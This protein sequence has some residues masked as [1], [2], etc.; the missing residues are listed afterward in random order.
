[1]SRMLMFVFGLAVGFAAAFL[2][3]A[4][5]SPDAPPPV[6]PPVQPR[7]PD[8]AARSEPADRRAEDRPRRAAADPL[9]GFDEGDLPA[10]TPGTG[11]ITGRVLD[12]A[13]HGL[14]GAT[15]R[16]TPQDDPPPVRETAT[17]DPDEELR[18]NVRD[19]VRR[20]RFDR[21]WGRDAVTDAAGAFV[22]QGLAAR[23]WC[24]RAT[25]EGWDIGRA[26]GR[27]DWQAVRIG[28]EVAFTAR[29]TFLVEV[30]VMRPDG[31]P[32]ETAKVLVGERQSDS[33]PVDWNPDAPRMPLRAGKWILSATSGA[34]SEWRS[35]DVDVEVG[36]TAAPAPIR[37]VLAERPGVIV[38]LGAAGP[39]GP[40]EAC[41]FLKPEGVPAPASAAGR[42]R[43]PEDADKAKSKRVAP[44]ERTAFLDVAAGRWT[45]SLENG[46]G[47]EFYSE[48]LDVG[49]G[50]I[51]RDVALPDRDLRDWVVARVVGPD[52][53]PVAD[54]RFS[55]GYAAPGGFADGGVEA[56]RLDDSR[57]RVPAFPTGSSGSSSSTGDPDSSKATRRWIVAQ[58]AVLGSTHADIDPASGA[59]VELRFGTPA[60]L[61][62]KIEGAL[63][64]GPHLEVAVGNAEESGGTSPIVDGVYERRD[65]EGDAV[66]FGPF[67]PREASVELSSTDADDNR[68]DLASVKVSLVAGENAVTLVVPTFQPLRVAVPDN[69]NPWSVS[70]RRLGTVHGDALSK[71]ASG[72]LPAAWRALP[73]GRYRL[74]CPEGDMTLTLPC[75][76]EVRFVPKPYTALLLSVA[77]DSRAQAAGLRDGDL[78]VAIEGTAFENSKHIDA[79]FAAAKLKTSS[80]LSILRGG[81]RVEIEIDLSKIEVGWEYASR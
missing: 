1:M 60:R 70:L 57:W 67:S 53:S 65:V 37:L 69:V 22:V 35:P 15:V 73:P 32:P 2:L 19:L 81:Q 68:M 47:V 40:F 8:A 41:A 79:L 78:V 4:F 14:A 18:R 33:M 46:I 3:G 5:A 7:T 56:Q 12:A 27:A 48:T 39:K 17:S 31:T 28:E 38:T 36:D 58:S 11:R 43:T 66:A 54:V 59:E 45:L 61:S 44:G 13:G 24:L 26:D 63:A 51:R 64:G 10:T 76:P 75:P 49:A 34:D 55:G 42:R 72:N 20:R 25:L 50:L 6:E 16:A 62:V 52:G 77:D 29:R 71:D 23:A 74:S 80:R 9:A 30:A 21:A